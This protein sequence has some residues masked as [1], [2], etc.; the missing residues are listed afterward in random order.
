MIES[1]FISRFKCFDDVRLLVKGLTV[2]TGLNG[3]GKSSAIQALLLSRL[4]VDGSTHI[5][6][7]GPFGLALGEAVDVLTFDADPAEGIAIGLYDSGVEYRW[8]FGVGDPG[9]RRPY[10][11]VETRPGTLPPTVAAA[12]RR[13]TYLAAERLGP[14]DVVEASSEASSELEVGYAGQFTAQILNVCA[15]DPV[16]E[17]RRNQRNASRRLTDLHHQVEWWIG[18]IVRDVEIETEW[19]SGTNMVGLRFRGLGF[20]SEWTRPANTGFGL[21]YTLPI[22]VAGLLAPRGGLLVV[23]NP[24][25][26]LHPAG[27][28]A[29]G[30]FLARV[31]GDGVQVILETHSDHVISGIRRGIAEF[32]LVEAPDVVVHFFRGG[33]DRPETLDIA[34][35]GQISGW[36]KG[37]FDQIEI[38]LAAL[39]RIG[40]RR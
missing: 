15:K 40:R 5:P 8:R 32:R 1:L 30:A 36:P 13:F 23:E 11:T 22:V 38:D 18:E 4:A 16:P 34:D 25:A 14:R 27:Q 35:S 28:S 26:H 9:L 31:A 2:L 37:F 19:Y 39:A 29:M 24:E 10:L 6:L 21:T 12:G 7:N 33:K 17:K 20:R 3:A